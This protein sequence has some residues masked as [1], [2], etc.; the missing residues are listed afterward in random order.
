MRLPTLRLRAALAAA[1]LLLAP[2]SAIAQRAE[3]SRLPS[4]CDYGRCAYNIIAALHGLRVTRG[5]QEEAVATLGFLWTRDISTAFDGE[6]AR[7]ARDAV[8][9]RRVGAVFTDLG[10]ALLAV[11]ASRA[12]ARSLDETAAHLMLGGAASLGISVPIQFTADKHLARAVW[13]HNARYAAG[14]TR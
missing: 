3:P 5:A 8:R 9:T 1:S 10:V 12:A 2:A 14:A 6:A 13:Q 4:D 7:V 11:G